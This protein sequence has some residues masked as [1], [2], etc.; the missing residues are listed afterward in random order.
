MKIQILT[1][2]SCDLPREYIKEHAEY[3]RVLGMP[4]QVDGGDFIDDLGENTNAQLFYDNL[5]N[6][7]FAKTSQI[8]PSVFQNV[9]EENIKNEI[10]TIYIGLSSS[11]SG[12]YNNAVLS[13][14]MVEEH[15][16]KKDYIYLPDIQSASVGT[17]ICVMKAMELIDNGCSATDISEWLVSHEKNIHHWFAVDDI[18]YL[19]RGGRISHTG[20][21]VATVLNIK[22]VL[23]LNDEG[24]IVLCK[25]VRGRK[26]SIKF[27]FSKVK[28]YADSNL[29]D[30]I[31]IGHGD[32][33]DD[34]LVLKETLSEI[35]DI[36]NI[37]I[38]QLSYTISTHVGPDMLALTFL[39]EDTTKI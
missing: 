3:I 15:T 19:R 9:F 30:K 1:D 38:S 29:F 35:W 10:Y 25:S 2:S 24:N 33:Y 12:T 7:V 31:I 39:G 23:T 8:V 37:I 28:D 27:L 17:G 4:I 26:K 14:N 16:G 11:L 13:K 36:N 20:A 5:R 18:E 34:A 6:S 21:K 22:P 32:C